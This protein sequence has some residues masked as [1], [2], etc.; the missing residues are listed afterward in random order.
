MR[1]RTREEIKACEHAPLLEIGER[2]GYA[3]QGDY[4]YAVKGCPKCGGVAQL[5]R[6]HLNRSG[7][8]RRPPA[9]LAEMNRGADEAYR[10]MVRDW[11]EGLPEPEG[12]QS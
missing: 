4:I 5:L 7:S 2:G 10:K 3:A 6:L 9:L 8:K 11:R 1:Q 12:E